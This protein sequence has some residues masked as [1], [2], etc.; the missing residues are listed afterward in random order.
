VRVGVLHGD[1]VMVVHHVFR[2]GGG[3]QVLEV[4]SQIPAHASALGKAM[5]AYAPPEVLDELT[6]EPLA[7]LTQR[8]LTAARLR[9]ELA[10]VRERGFARE[11]DEAVLG[12]ASVG[13]PI[14]DHTGQAVGAIGA[15]GDSARLLP[16]GPAKGLAAAVTEAARAISR[17][18]GGTRYRQG[19]A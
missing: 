7:R 6:S 1:S 5:L 10:D 17:E 4:G 9:G 16:R 8:T 11:R 12:E 2:P 18:L 3:F 13:A 14:V 15:V 19:H